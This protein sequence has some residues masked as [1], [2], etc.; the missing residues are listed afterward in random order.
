MSSSQLRALR[1]EDAEQVAA[2][3]VAAFGESRRLDADEIRSWLRN[4][5]IEASW[6]RVLEVAGRV[7]GYGD[8][9][10]ETEVVQL[11]VAAPGH[12]ETFF[13]WAEREARSRG[14]PRVRAYFEA[15]HELEEL[16]AA[17][18]YRYF[19]SSY[20][21]DI[22]L[23]ARSPVMLPEGIELR[24]FREED[25]ALLR[26]ALNEAFVGDPFWHTVSQSNFREF[27]LGARGF[28]SALWLLAWDGPELAGFA[29]NYPERT[30]DRTLGWVGTL[31]VRSPWRRRGLGEALLR[32]AFNALYDRGLRRAGLGVDAENAT[33]ALR[34]YEGAGMQRVRQNDSWELEVCDVDSTEPVD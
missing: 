28:D 22:T 10:V 32:S 1:E 15:G 20:T 6:F 4:D 13:D 31:G 5:E 9:F 12:W 27:Y 18:G 11:D 25:E 3:F 26:S 29:L 30:G 34:L 17:R 33:G 7:V 14:V 8:I 21:M 16:V 2:L 19:R 24:A 23:D